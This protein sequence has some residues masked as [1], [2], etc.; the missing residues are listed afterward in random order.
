M[1]ITERLDW[2]YGGNERRDFKPIGNDDLKKFLDAEGRLKHPNELR[3][4]IYEGGIEPL[5][6]K[7]IWRHLLNIF[8]TDM[9][10]LDRVEYLKEV[11][12]KYEK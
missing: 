11:S 1:T 3:Q 9:T 7:V 8:G 2:M 5:S 4:A 12:I 10:S 6:R